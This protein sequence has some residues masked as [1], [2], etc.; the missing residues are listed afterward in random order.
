MV[1]RNNSS[2]KSVRTYLRSGQ[3]LVLGLQVV[4]N[5]VELVQVPVPE[6]RVVDE[7]ELTSGVLERASVAFTREVHPSAVGLLARHRRSE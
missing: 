1:V 4:H 7:V 6:H 3:P 5:L 2:L